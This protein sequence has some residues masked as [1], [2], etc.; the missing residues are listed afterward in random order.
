MAIYKIRQQ[1]RFF[2]S[3]FDRTLGSWQAR[4]GTSL[5]I[6]GK[7]LNPAIN[8]DPQVCE[9]LS[10]IGTRA[11]TEA[12]GFDCHLSKPLDLRALEHLLD[13]T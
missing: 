2:G 13:S 7:L 9:Y 5:A 6:I 1:Q 8:Q 10:A 12:A 11:T 4:T 3:F